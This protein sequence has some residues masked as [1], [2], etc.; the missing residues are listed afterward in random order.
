MSDFEQERYQKG[1]EILRRWAAKRRDEPK[2]LYPDLYDLSVGYLFARSGRVH[3][4]APR[5]RADH[6]GVQH[7]AGTA[8]RKRIRTTAAPSTIGLSHEEFMELI[9]QV[10]HYAAGRH[11]PRA[12]QYEEVSTRMPRKKRRRNNAR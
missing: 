8:E 12:H 5:P 7:R 10:G 1:M 4:S 6:D 11:G 9:I 3:I 2:R